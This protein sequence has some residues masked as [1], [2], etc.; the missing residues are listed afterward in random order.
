MLRQLTFW[1]QQRHLLCLGKKNVC[2]DKE[3]W[4]A[5][6]SLAIGYIGYIWKIILVVE[7]RSYSGDNFS[8]VH[9]NDYDLNVCGFAW[10]EICGDVLLVTFFGS[11]IVI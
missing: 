6:H 8:V 5:Y 2:Y 9:G 4:I 3:S 7:I 11:D 10:Y 1:R